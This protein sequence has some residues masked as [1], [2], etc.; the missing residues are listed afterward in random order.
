MRQSREILPK[1]TPKDDS[2]YFKELTKAIFRAA[3]PI[4]HL[5]AVQTRCSKILN[6]FIGNAAKFFGMSRTRFQYGHHVRGLA[7]QLL[8]GQFGHFR[9][10]IGRQ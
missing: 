6:R 10:R 2:G 4:R 3:E 8:G 5:D 9:V 7:E 1:I